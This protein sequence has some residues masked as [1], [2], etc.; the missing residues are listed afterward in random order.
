MVPGPKKSKSPR[1]FLK[2]L[3]TS[4]PL[5]QDPSYIQKVE[6]QF[7]EEIVRTAILLMAK[8]I[9]SRLFPDYNTVNDDDD[10][11]IIDDN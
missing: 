3:G 10:G 5:L 8:K 7:E 6:E 1:T 11:M 9:V 4:R 2:G